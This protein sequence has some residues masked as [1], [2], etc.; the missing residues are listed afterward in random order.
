ML[1]KASILTEVMRC[2]QKESILVF[3]LVQTL[4][5][6]GEFPDAGL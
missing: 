6:A 3:G 4:G 5:K 2:L 1:L